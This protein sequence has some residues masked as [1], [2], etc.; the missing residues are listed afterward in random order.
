MVYVNTMKIVLL[1][2]LVNFAIIKES[3]AQKISCGTGEYLV[4]G[5]FRKAYIKSDGTSVKATNVVTHCKKLT[6]GYDFNKIIKEGL[7]TEWPHKTEKSQ[8]WTTEEINRLIEVIEGLPDYLKS[9]YINGIYR[10]QKSKDISNPAA[11][12]DNSEIVLYDETFSKNRNLSRIVAHEFAHQ[13]YSK[14]TDDEK[15]DYRRA[16]GWNIKYGKNRD[17]YTERRKSGYIEPDGMSSANEDFANNLEHF[18]FNS[19]KLKT[20]TPSAY[21]WFSKKYGTKPKN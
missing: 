3:Q 12:S 1:F 9:L 15:L 2:I 17:Y 19:D 8:K 21:N 10:L 20:I 6:S 4:T 7:P 14:M 16:T 18:I 13:L 11:N 5:H